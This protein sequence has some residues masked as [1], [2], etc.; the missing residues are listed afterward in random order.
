MADRTRTYKSTDWQVW[1]YQ[2]VAGKFRLDF[3]LLNGSDVLGGATDTGGMVQTT[4]PVSQIT[5]E[6]GANLEQGI[7]GLLEGSKAN[8]TLEVSTVNKTAM[9]EYYTGKRV[10]ITLKNEETT[11]TH[12]IFGQNTPMFTGFIT[13]AQLSYVPGNIIHA[14]TIEAQDVMQFVLNNQ[15]SIKKTDSSFYDTVNGLYSLKSAG[16]LPDDALNVNYSPIQAGEDWQLAQWETYGTPAEI[17]S[18]GDWFSNLSYLYSA[19][20]A[21]CFITNVYNVSASEFGFFRHIYFR[22]Q[23]DTQLSPVVNIPISQ[24]YNVQLEGDMAGK[25]NIFSLSTPSGAQAQT[26]SQTSGSVNSMIQMSQTIDCNVGVLND[27]ISRITAI[28][29]E[30]APIMLEVIQGVNNQPIIFN[31]GL[32]TLDGTVTGYYYPKAYKPVTT[33]A[34]FDLSSLGFSATEVKIVYGTRMTITPDTWTT[35]Y[36]LGKML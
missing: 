17:K 19:L 10:V 28:K 25:P 14:L 24:I 34:I 29:N 5:I 22:P 27:I 33:K 35:Q 4:L 23:D 11:R 8:I 21:P 26:G 7:S 1:F 13:T 3:S 31:N 36:M 18:I 20:Y 2:P 32:F 12:A 16:Q 9:A 6:D 15:L 30:Y